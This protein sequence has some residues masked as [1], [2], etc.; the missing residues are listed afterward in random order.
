MTETTTPKK[1]IWQLLK[2]FRELGGSK[3]QYILA[4][5]APDLPRHVTVTSTLPVPRKGNPGTLKTAVNVHYGVKLDVG[6]P[7]ER[8]V[9]IVAKC[10]TSFPVGTTLADQKAAVEVLRK[11]INLGN[12]TRETADLFRIGILPD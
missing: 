1:T 4:E 11:V 8:L 12:G 10:E 6:L 3:T 7:T 9:P 2:K 5:H